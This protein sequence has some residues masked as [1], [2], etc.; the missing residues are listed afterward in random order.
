MIYDLII[1]IFFYNNNNNNNNNNNE[2]TL[3]ISNIFYNLRMAQNSKY[4]T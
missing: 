1:Y 3:N 2:E 4:L